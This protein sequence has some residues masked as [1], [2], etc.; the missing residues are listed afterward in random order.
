MHFFFKFRDSPPTIDT[1]IAFPYMEDMTDVDGLAP[2]QPLLNDGKW[3]WPGPMGRKKKAVKGLF[4]FDSYVSTDYILNGYCNKESDKSCYAMGWPSCCLT[5]YG[6]SCPS[7][8]KPACDKEE[9]PPGSPYCTYA[10]DK[11]CYEL[12]WPT[13][14]SDDSKECP[15]EPPHCDIQCHTLGKQ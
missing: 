9:P 1:T 12:G 14:C 2:T 8:E 3:I 10:P 13:C 6:P 4:T 15:K 7:N 11:T 5:K